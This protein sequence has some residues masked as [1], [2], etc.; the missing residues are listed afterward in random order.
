MLAQLEAAA[1]HYT[2]PGNEYQRSRF[3]DPAFDR[4]KLYDPS[5]I[6][7]GCKMSE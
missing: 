6:R 7:M 1:L 3:Y 5:S 2:I 4:A